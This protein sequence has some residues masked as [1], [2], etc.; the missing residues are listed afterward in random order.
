MGFGRAVAEGDRVAQ[1][2]LERIVTP[3]VLE[4]EVSPVREAKEEEVLMGSFGR[5]AE[6]VGDGARRGRLWFDWIQV[7]ALRTSL[8]ARTLN[9]VPSLAPS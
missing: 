3:E 7:M 4:V 5:R 9:A 8:D 1:L 6:L 2:I